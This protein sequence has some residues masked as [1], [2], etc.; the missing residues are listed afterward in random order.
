MDKSDGPAEQK[1]PLRKGDPEP[2]YDYEPGPLVPDASGLKSWL[3]AHRG[4]R[5]RVPVVFELGEPGH[6]FRRSHI[7]AVEVRVT[8]L[9]LGIPLSERIA[10]KCGRDARRCA[11]W[12]E[13]RYG[14]SPPVA[15]ELPQFE[16]F[17]VG[18]VVDEQAPLHVGRAK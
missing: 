1:R 9:A 10:Q 2:V 5:L 13:G 12:L 4:W 15:D 7:G 11:L 6:G 18:E 16:V 14:E 3:E 17:K 8:D